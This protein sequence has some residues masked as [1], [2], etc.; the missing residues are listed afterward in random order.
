[1]DLHHGGAPR[2]AQSGLGRNFWQARVRLES[3][4]EAEAGLP[5]EK[6][7]PRIETD[8]VPQ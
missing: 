2:D 5:R 4:H 8:L 3:T 6:E 1:V 7:I